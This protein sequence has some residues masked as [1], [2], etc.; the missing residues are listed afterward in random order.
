MTSCRACQFSSEQSGSS[1]AFR[2]ASSMRPVML[3][4]SV[5][6]ALAS[7]LMRGQASAKLS[8]SSVE[9]LSYHSV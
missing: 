4:V 3:D 6:R 7:S 9:R 5:S 1:L 2:P 8:C